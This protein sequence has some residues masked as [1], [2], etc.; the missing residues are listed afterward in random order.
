MAIQLFSKYSRECQVQYRFIHYIGILLTEQT[1][2]ASFPVIWHLCTSFQY[3][4][5]GVNANEILP[6][7]LEISNILNST[8]DL[9][10][11]IPSKWQA[12]E[13][14]FLR[15][16]EVVAT[17]F[18]NNGHLARWLANLTLKLRPQ[19]LHKTESCM[20]IASEDLPALSTLL[21][22]KRW[23]PYLSCATKHR[24]C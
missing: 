20:K 15:R 8:Y 1:S 3:V 6:K 5:C 22:L 24:P 16:V 19:C 17:V 2:T 4:C 11:G 14:V 9:E 12:F 18:D 21:A 10:N 13:T 23:L 7:F